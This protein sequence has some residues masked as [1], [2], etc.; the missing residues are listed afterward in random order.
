MMEEKAPFQ[1]AAVLVPVFRG[2]DG[3]LWVVLVRRTEIGIHGGQIAFPGGKREEEDG[4]L[5]ET[6]L[7]EA[8]EEIGL[9]PA[10]VKVLDELP[11]V[12][13]SVSEFRIQPFLAVIVPPPIWRLAEEEIADVFEARIRDLLAPECHGQEHWQL[14]GW[15]HPRSVR[16]YNVSGHKL[17]GA[18]YR[19][20]HPLLPRL[21]AGDWEV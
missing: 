12:E 15:K 5:L 3:E 18:S 1:D 21:L 16:F 13:T 2:K 20:L 4:S 14:S 11:V 19:I 9:D 10:R 17:W 8:R 6:A 7:R